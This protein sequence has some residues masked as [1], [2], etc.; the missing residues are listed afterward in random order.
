MVGRG[1]LRRTEESPEGKAASPYSP[2]RDSR[3][4]RAVAS[5]PEPQAG[6]QRPLNDV[7]ES[8]VRL[9]TCCC[10]VEAKSRRRARSDPEL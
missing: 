9:R 6:H 1:L 2:P 5:S 3:P 10:F 4:H 7:T 8:G